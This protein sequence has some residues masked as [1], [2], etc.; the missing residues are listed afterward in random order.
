[1]ADG[2]TALHV[3]STFGHIQVLQL[4]LEAWGH[5]AVPA[6]VLM[7]AGQL[8]A[9]HMHFEAAARLLKLTQQLYP[10]ELQQQLAGV[11]T[12]TLAGVLDAWSADIS[13][14]EEQRAAMH[15]RE[16]DL[17]AEKRAVQ[18]LIVQMAC[19]AKQTQQTLLQGQ[20]SHH[21]HGRGSGL[22]ESDEQ[23]RASQ[24]STVLMIGSSR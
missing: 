16:Q 14:I 1:M 23:H 4:L 8:A 9:D 19:M 2:R 3:A 11:S 17:A 13:S 12:P 7:G 22:V 21:G 6:A 15:R 5:P 10:A 18:Q 24:S 20:R